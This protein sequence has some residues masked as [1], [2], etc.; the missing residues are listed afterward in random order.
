MSELQFTV[1]ITPHTKKHLLSQ[2][3][4]TKYSWAVWENEG[5]TQADST[6]PLYRMALPKHLKSP[7][8]PTHDLA[9]AAAKECIAMMQTRADEMETQTT[10]HN[11]A[12]VLKEI[13][14]A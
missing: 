4:D 10:S 13:I 7:Y 9:M 11:G 5:R 2:R 8:Y 14:A 3:I 6:N 12:R 1:K